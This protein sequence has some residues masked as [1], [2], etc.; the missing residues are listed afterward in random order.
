MY[1]IKI[2]TCFYNSNSDSFS[3]IYNSSNLQH[4]KLKF[5]NGHM[6]KFVNFHSTAWILQNFAWLPTS[7]QPWVSTKSH[8]ELCQQR[9]WYTVLSSILCIHS[10]CIRVQLHMLPSFVTV[11]QVIDYTI[12]LRTFQDLC[13]MNGWIMIWPMCVVEYFSQFWGTSSQTT[14]YNISRK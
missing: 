3:L 4:D 10:L 9:N 8:K 1:N 12:V 6:Q 2:I 11:N 5:F 14:F 7:P 13:R